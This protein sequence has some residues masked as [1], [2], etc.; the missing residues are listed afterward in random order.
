MNEEMR[1]QTNVPNDVACQ[2]GGDSAQNYA[3]VEQV[4]PK[5]KKHF[6]SSVVFSSL[7]LVATAI[8]AV[9]MGL[10]FKEISAGNGLGFAVLVILLLIPA[11]IVAILAEVFGSLAIVA[12]VKL[13]KG[14]DRKKAIYGKIAVA[15]NAVLMFCALALVAALFIIAY[16]NNAA[17]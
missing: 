14:E 6:T 9:C 7:C 11:I 13:I 2:V 15:V 17:A 1:N 16:A 10:M 3:A 4:K 8:V 12:S 5:K